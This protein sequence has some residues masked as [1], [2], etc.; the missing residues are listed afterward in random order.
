MIRSINTLL[1]ACLLSACSAQDSKENNTS[2]ETITAEKTVAKIP[3]VTPLKVEKP[4]VEKPVLEKQ[5]VENRNE[6]SKAEI[7]KPN[8]E[9]SPLKVETSANK[10]LFTLTTLEGKTITIKETAGGLVFEEFKDKAVILIFF[11]YKCPPCRAEIPVL[12]A[13]INKGHKDLEIIALEVQ[14]LK[15]ED[16]KVFKE[17]KGINYNLVA[18]EGNYKFISYIGDKANWK[19]AIPFLIGFN[20]KGEVNVVHVGGIGASEFDNIYESIS[21]VEKK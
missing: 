16:L 5:V 7:I 12:K 19:G 21:K 13:L 4:V 10:A 14:G 18:G 1:F 2:N 6:T 20:K 3:Q 17:K 15:K 8:V 11:G 9:K